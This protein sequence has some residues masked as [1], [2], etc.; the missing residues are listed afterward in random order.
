M[1]EGERGKRGRSVWR[2]REKEGKE[3]FRIFFLRG[4]GKRTEGVRECICRWGKGGEGVCSLREEG[5]RGS[6]CMRV[7]ID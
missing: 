5:G 4:K 1:R 7:V 3:G 2:G 6:L